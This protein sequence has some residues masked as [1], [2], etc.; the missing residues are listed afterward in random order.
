MAAP[1]E[2]QVGPNKTDK[3]QVSV[4]FFLIDPSLCYWFACFN[5]FNLNSRQKQKAFSP[6]DPR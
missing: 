2:A 5:N 3:K 4:F 1:S 6:A